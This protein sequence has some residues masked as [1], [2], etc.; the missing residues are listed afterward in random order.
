MGLLLSVNEA[1]NLIR[2]GQTLLFAGD[3]GLL[4]ELPRGQWVGGTIPYFMAESGGVTDHQRIFVTR[5][6]GVVEKTTVKLYSLEDL[7]QMPRDYPKNGFSFIL[8][9]AG[10]QVHESYSRNCSTWPG[11]F[12]SPVVGWVT[13]VDLKD[14]SRIKPKVFNGLTGEWSDSKALVMHAELPA[15]KF[16]KIRIL[17]LFKQGH[18][19]V[20]TFPNVSFEITDCLINGKPTNFFQYI[21]EREINTQLPL[22]ASYVGEMVNVS[23]QSVSQEQR[24]VMIYAP[25]FPGVEYRMAAPVGDYVSEFRKLISTLPPQSTFSCN[26]ILNFLYADLE[27]KRTGSPGPMTFGEVAYMLL[28]QTM[29]YMTIESN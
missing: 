26:C 16:A 29:V 10:S 11:F 17:N 18:G 7:H 8:L 1:A 9:P 25:V 15:G 23:F 22:V 21:R 5:L 4:R 20:I 28:N 6:S 14:L 2:E 19:D 12:N 24:K 27:G 13:G 3:E